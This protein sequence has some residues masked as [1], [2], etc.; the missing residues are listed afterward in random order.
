MIGPD[1]MQL[2]ISDFPEQGYCH[3]VTIYIGP[4][5]EQ[6]RYLQIELEDQHQNK[7]D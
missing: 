1:S 3:Q 6:F 5:A 7:Y 2:A 4:Q